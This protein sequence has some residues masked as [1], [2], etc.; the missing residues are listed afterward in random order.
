LIRLMDIA[1]DWLAAQGRTG[2][3][4]TERPSGRPDR[5]T[6]MGAF[7]ESGGLWVVVDEGDGKAGPPEAQKESGTDGVL[8]AICVGQAMPYVEPA[9]Q[10]ELYIRFLIT[11][12][13]STRRGLGGVLLDKSRDLA[14]AAGVGMLRVDCYAGDDQKLVRWYESQGFQRAEA[15]V[16]QGWP[17]QVLVQ[18]LGATGD[19]ED[20]IDNSLGLQGAA[21]VPD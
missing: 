19:A 13:S 17:G 18:R 2:Q 5:V 10:P 16:V 4:G 6:T 8:G 3:W 1:T 14:R 21:G 11:D 7:A 15:F 9:S 20:S 12:R